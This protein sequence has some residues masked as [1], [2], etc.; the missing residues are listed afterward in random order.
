MTAKKRATL[1]GLD[2]LARLKFQV[3]EDGQTR[4]E[5]QM[6]DFRTTLERRMEKIEAQLTGQDTRID[7]HVTH[8]GADKVRWSITAG[9]GT[10]ALGGLVTLL[11]I[12]LTSCT[13][14]EIPEW[15]FPT[16]TPTEIVTVSPIETPTEM[17]TVLPSVSPSPTEIPTETATALPSP[18][19]LPSLTATP[20]PSPTVTPITTTPTAIPVIEIIELSFVNPGFEGL[21]HNRIIG[22]QSY[23][24]MQ[25]ADG[26][27]PIACDEPFVVGGCPAPMPCP[28]GQTTSCNPA[29]ARMGLP[30]WKPAIGQYYPTRVYAGER[31]QQWFCYSRTCLAGIYQTVIVPPG[32]DHCTVGARVQSWSQNAATVYTSQL[33][34]ADDR[35]N[36]SWRILVDYSGG[37][38]PFA[39]GTLASRE[40]GYSDWIYDQWASIEFSFDVGRAGG[41]HTIF[42]MDRRLWP[43]T[44][45]DSYID[46]VWGLCERSVGPTPTPLPPGEPSPTPISGS[47]WDS[48]M[49]TW[50][51]QTETNIRRGPG[52]EFGRRVDASGNYETIAAGECITIYD[53]QGRTRT[54]SD[55]ALWLNCTG[56]DIWGSDHPY[57]ARYFAL[58]WGGACFG[59]FYS[60]G[61]ASGDFAACMDNEGFDE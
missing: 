49:G 34:T 33:A 38:N 56:C 3:I 24:T 12:L 2:E 17:V 37:A 36:S 60:H 6:G 13:G 52:A 5:E 53:I 31:A 43:L 7:K 59:T 45:N 58:R 23:N 15:P 40:F 46:N 19:A 1:T 8:I 28:A 35:Q 18:S 21:Y 4:L 25:M 10:A 14:G 9:I 42:F 11:V 16:E 22:E 47:V 51:A 61:M 26:W 57:E 41:P 32:Y 48:P 20:L 55:P 54:T 39:P 30:E 27:E 50:C 44:H 29:G